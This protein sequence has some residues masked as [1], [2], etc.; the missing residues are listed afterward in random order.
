MYTIYLFIWMKVVVK[1]EKKKRIHEAVL[2]IQEQSCGQDQNVQRPR[3]IFGLYLTAQMDHLG[4][5]DG[6]NL[7]QRFVTY[8]SISYF[9]R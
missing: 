8:F 5:H 6:C 2:T 9:L 7:F 1:M 4:I 3:T